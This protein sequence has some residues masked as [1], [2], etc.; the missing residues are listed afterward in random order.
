MIFSNRKFPAEAGPRRCCLH[1]LDVRVM[2]SWARLASCCC[3]CSAGTWPCSP[4]LK[5]HLCRPTLRRRTRSGDAELS[6]ASNSVPRPGIRVGKKTSE[7]MWFISCMAHGALPRRHG[8]TYLFYGLSLRGDDGIFLVKIMVEEERCQCLAAE[9]CDDRYH[10]GIS[11]CQSS[12]QNFHICTH[13]AVEW[14][15][16]DSHLHCAVFLDE[17][18]TPRSRLTIG[19]N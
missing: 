2:P 16:L 15:D 10:D 7:W 19:Y 12:P 18:P 3:T 4:C 14:E 17:V 5:L 8:R 13:H 11:A 9:R 6:G 1:P